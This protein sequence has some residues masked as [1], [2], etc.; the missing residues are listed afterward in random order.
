V[1]RVFICW[2][3]QWAC[4]AMRGSGSWVARVRAG[5]AV[6]SPV[7]PRATQT[8]RSRPLRLVRRMGVPWNLALKAG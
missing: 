7:L 3:A 1:E 2:M 6:V 5:R 4:S 8:F